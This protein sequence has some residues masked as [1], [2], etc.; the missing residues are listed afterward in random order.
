MNNLRFQ[1]LCLLRY[2]LSVLHALHRLGWVHRDI[3]YGNVLI[4]EGRGKITDLEYS[5]RVNDNT[6]PHGIRTVRLR[7]LFITNDAEHATVLGHPILHVSR[8][9]RAPISSSAT[10]RP[11]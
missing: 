3:S 2:I 5:K 9:R 11:R 1:L 8:G 6:G 10:R 7:T 4:V